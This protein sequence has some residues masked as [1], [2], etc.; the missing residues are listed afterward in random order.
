[1][2]NLL[3]VCIN[4]LTLSFV[5]IYVMGKILNQKPNYRG[6]IYYVMLLICAFYLPISYAITQSFAKILL[7]F[8]LFIFLCKNIYKA[9][10]VRSVLVALLTLFLSVISEIFYML[11]ITILF[12]NN[13]EFLHT[14]IL[15]SAMS[16]ITISFINF[17]LINCKFINKHFYNIVMRFNSPVNTKQIF[18]FSL[19]SIFTIS[20]VLYYTYFEIG[21][22]TSFILCLIIIVIYLILALTLYKEKNEYEKLKIQYDSVSDSLS[23][24]EKLYSYQR[25]LNHEFKNDLMVIRG[26]SNNDN[27]KLR[28]YI[29]SIVEVKNNKD[30]K[31]LNELRRIPEGGLLGILYYKLLLMD[32]KDINVDFVIGRNFESEKFNK[33]SEVL[34][35]KICK[36]I[37][38]FLDN[39]IQ[40]VEKS[41]EKQISIEL[42]IVDSY[43]V[44]KISN[45]FS[46]SIDLSRIYEKGYT[47]KEKGHGY[48]LS[49]AKEII[50]KE[51]NIICETNVNG[52]TF[53]QNIKIKL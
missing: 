13:L 9:N 39:S 44:C 12:N 26:L 2:I 53:S 51:E 42:D 36:L 35:I 19:L 49:I 15:G 34:K 3:I 52:N 16:N 41:K 18:F 30:D 8:L 32:D 27:T 47:T 4:S 28:E 43:F 48:G 14:N 21:L 22:T 38:I 6:Y 11:I 1:M 33:I 37:G 25:L 50:E 5:Q 45:N 17:I 24:Y 31:W 40:A 10:F 46:G 23:E 7:T 29:D 20:I